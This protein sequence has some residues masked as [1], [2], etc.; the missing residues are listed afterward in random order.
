MM[1]ESYDSRNDILYLMLPCDT[2]NNYGDKI[3]D[4]IYLLRDMNTDNVNGIMIF[5][6]IVNPVSMQE[7]T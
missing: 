2:G 7:H 5:H 3:A 6:P 1:T 4:N